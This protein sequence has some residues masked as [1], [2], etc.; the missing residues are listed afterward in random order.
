LL[1]PPHNID[2]LFIVI[3]FSIEQSFLKLGV[4]LHVL[5]QCKNFQSPWTIDRNDAS[6]VVLGVVMYLNGL[7]YIQLDI[8]LQ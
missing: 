8:S 5:K 1:H 3:S 6:N 2:R 7:H 4:S